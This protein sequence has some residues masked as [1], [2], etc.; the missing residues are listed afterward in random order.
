MVSKV[1]L[2]KSNKEKLFGLVHDLFIQVYKLTTEV[3]ELR[4]EIEGITTL[5]RR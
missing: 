2:R 3:K 4:E 5:V 1:E